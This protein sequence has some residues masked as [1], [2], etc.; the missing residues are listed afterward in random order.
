M[1][2]SITWAH[3]I[4]LTVAFFLN[5]IQEAWAVTWPEHLGSMLV[6]G[7]LADRRDDES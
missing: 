3:E 5:Q 4:E 1:L 6:T 2:K 7:R